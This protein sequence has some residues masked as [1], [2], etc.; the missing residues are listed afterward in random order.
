MGAVGVAVD[1]TEDAEAFGSALAGL[2]TPPNSTYKAVVFISTNRDAMWKHGTAIDPAQAKN[3]ST[4]AFLDHAKMSLREFMRAGGGFVGIH[5]AFGTESNWPY[6]EG[7]LG[8]A[9]YYSNG[10]LQSG[11]A[12]IVAND[13]STD[14]LP[15][16]LT[17][18]DRW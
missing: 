8:N 6:Y 13:S 1:Y 10:P 7:L 2:G 14:G 5:N 15:S 16:S 17:F 18:T 4:N 3:T 9:N 11:K 12:V